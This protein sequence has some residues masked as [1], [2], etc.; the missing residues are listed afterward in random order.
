MYPNLSGLWDLINMM[1]NTAFVFLPALVGW[2]ATK[3]FGGSPILGIVMGLMLVHPALL[4]A[5]DYG[6]AA[7][8]L[9]GQKIEYFD[10]LGLF[11]IE[12]VGYQGQILPVLV[13]AFVLSKV[14]IFLKKHVPNA[15]QLL[16]VPITTI[17]VTG[18]LALGIIGPVTRHI[19]DLLTAGLV[20]VYE[21]VPVVGAV[22]FGA[23]YAP[24]GGTFIWPMIAL[25]NI[26]QGSAALA[27][28]WISKN[29][30]DKS[31][32][33]TSAISAY[34]GI[35]EPAMF[36]VNLR[37][38]F[39][40][41]AAIIGSAVAA[42]FIT[43]NGVLAPAIGIG[44][45]PAFISIIPKSIPM[46]IVGMIIAVVIPFTLTWLFAKRVKQK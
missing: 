19:G 7:T 45:L 37:N 28:F 9:D 14:E 43:L 10:I 1:A 24:H 34:F 17:V 23:L 12:K 46:F 16:V 5:W 8:G 27:M 26:A 20:G 41:Y 40:F 32:A 42:I 2:S 13:A 4:N 22:L 35:T 33:S 36:G 31:M 25:S 29:Q 3:R 11:Q 30:N 18:V 44:G 15:I 6:K 21:T 38:K 39:P